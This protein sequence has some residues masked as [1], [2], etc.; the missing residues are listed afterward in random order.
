MLMT[1][2]RSTYG[3]TCVGMRGLPRP[4]PWPSLSTSYVISHFLSLPQP[5]RGRI[6]GEIVALRLP[7]ALLEANVL[8]PLRG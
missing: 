8:S 7:R 5:F 2:D 4:P 6:D 3:A 1:N